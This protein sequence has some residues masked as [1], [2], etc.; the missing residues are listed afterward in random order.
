MTE[1]IIQTRILTICILLSK[2][3][4]VT[5]IYPSLPKINGI[6]NC[7]LCIKKWNLK[8]FQRQNAI[9]NICITI[10]IIIEEM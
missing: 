1:Q 10:Q 3:H 5:D 9:A 6:K 2:I 7:C 8:I 4:Q